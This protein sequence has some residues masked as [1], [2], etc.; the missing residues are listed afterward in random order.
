MLVAHSHVLEEQLFTRIGSLCDVHLSLR[1]EK[2]RSKL[3][4]TLEIVKVLNAKQ[5]TGNVIPFEVEPGLGIRIT[6]FKQVRL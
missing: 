3:I 6:P 1:V 2:N 4:K 5:I